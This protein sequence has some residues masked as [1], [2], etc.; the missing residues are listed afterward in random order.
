MSYIRYGH[1]LQW[2][3]DEST[4]YVYGCGEH[5][6]EDYNSTYNNLPSL[7]ELMGHMVMWQTGDFGYATKMVVILACRLGIKHKLRLTAT[8]P[9]DVFELGRGHDY[10]KE[11]KQWVEFFQEFSPSGGCYHYNNDDLSDFDFLETFKE[12]ELM[13]INE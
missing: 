12:E 3:N 13:E 11:I 5:Q 2:F 6:I 9:H 1:P 7:V 10:R 4:E 8:H